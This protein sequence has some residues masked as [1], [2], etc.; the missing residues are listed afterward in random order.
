V[1]QRR[2]PVAL[3]TRA[4]ASATT[5]ASSPKGRSSCATSSSCALA[6]GRGEPGVQQP[7]VAGTAFAQD[8]P[9]G[10][11]PVDRARHTGRGQPHG[12]GD[13]THRGLLAGCVRDLAQRLQTGQGEAVLA[14]QGRVHPPG[15]PVVHLD[16]PQPG[17]CGAWVFVRVCVVGPLHASIVPDDGLT[18]S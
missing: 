1:T 12:L 7:L 13:L 18:R 8:Q 5:A 17:L 2:D 11:Q 16:D 6:A 9:V 4:R 3:D 10:D 14:V 15:D